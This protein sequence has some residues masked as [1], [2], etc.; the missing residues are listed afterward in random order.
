[1]KKKLLCTLLAALMLLG[2]TAC[3]GGDTPEN[4][5][6]PEKNAPSAPAAPAAKDPVTLKMLDDGLGVWESA[7]DPI[8]ER[9]NELHPEAPITIE[10]CAYGTTDE[11]IE[12]NLGMGSTEYDI[13]AVDTPKV[14]E[15]S[16]KG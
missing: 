4:G 1:M 12:M 8:A 13:I 2:L 11:I 3:G 14:A 7:M 5:V 15:Y 10:Y 6:K 9:W 16:E